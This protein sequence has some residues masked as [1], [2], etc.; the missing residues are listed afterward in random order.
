MATAIS[1]RHPGD[2]RDLRQISQ[3]RYAC[4]FQKALRTTG[5]MKRPCIYI[6]A[7]RPDGVLYIGV[8]SDL[9]GRMAKHDQ[10]LVEG[11]TKKHGVKMLVYYEFFELM[12]YAIQREKRLKEWQ[13]AWKVRLIL[14]ANPAWQNLFDSATGEIAALPS[15]IEHER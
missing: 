5:H 1:K 3:R 10:G 7:S 14:S 11:F 12:P 2:G 13:R 15:D 6:L 9:H 8:T 4:A